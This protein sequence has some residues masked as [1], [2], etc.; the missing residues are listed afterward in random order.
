MKILLNSDHLHMVVLKQIVNNATLAMNLERERSVFDYIFP[1]TK[2]NLRLKNL[3]VRSDILWGFER[4]LKVT[5]SETVEIEFSDVDFIYKGL[6][7]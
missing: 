6:P 3:R 2:R 5:T 7:L 1:Y 4:A